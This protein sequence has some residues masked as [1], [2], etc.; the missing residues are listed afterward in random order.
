MTYLLQ[1]L[2]GVGFQLSANPIYMHNALIPFSPFAVF[3][4]ST[5]SP[6]FSR[7]NLN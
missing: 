6:Y 1:T 5:N 7:A 3:P 4:F 2:E